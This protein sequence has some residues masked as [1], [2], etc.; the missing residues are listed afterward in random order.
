MTNEN[1]NASAGIIAGSAMVPSVSGEGQTKTPDYETLLKNYNDLETKLSDQ[2][3]ELGEYRK[4]VNEAYPIL[5]KLG[6]SPELLNAIREGKIDDAVV[7]QLLSGNITP[8]EGEQIVTAATKEA[9]KEGKSE[10]MTQDQIDALISS[11]VN[12]V[13]KQMDSRV[14]ELR[15]EQEF[16]AQ[17]DEFVEKNSDIKDHIDAIQ[18]WLEENDSTDLVTAYYVVKGKMSESDARKQ[19]DLDRGEIAKNIAMNASGGHGSSGGT[20]QSSGASF[21]DF[22]KAPPSSGF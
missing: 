12:E 22:V 6:D 5:E 21:T 9:N 2:G 7:Q 19:A 3:A 17:I 14:S 20:V 10:N 15:N 18:E 11:K 13:I 16:K 1:T 4:F 8:K